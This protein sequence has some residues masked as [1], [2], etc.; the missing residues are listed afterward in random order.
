VADLLERLFH[1]VKQKQICLSD[2][3]PHDKMS[4]VAVRYLP[5]DG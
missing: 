3:N 4:F 2:Q 1:I 5:N